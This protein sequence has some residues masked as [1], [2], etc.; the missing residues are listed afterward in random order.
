MHLQ[1]EAQQLVNMQ[2]VLL[3]FLQQLCSSQTACSAAIFLLMKCTGLQTCSR[4]SDLDLVNLEQPQSRPVSLPLI[5]SRYNET[6]VQPG[7]L[8]QT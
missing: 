6:N 7:Q 3:W 1:D 2:A 4:C 8:G 5:I